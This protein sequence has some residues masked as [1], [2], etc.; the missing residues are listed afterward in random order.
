MSRT[1]ISVFGMGSMGRGM[2]HCLV[3]AGF[4]VTVFNRTAAKAGELSEAG[5]RVAP[6]AVAAATGKDLLLLSLSD[7]AAIDDLL[8]GTLDGV[9][10]PGT[11]VINTSTV[12]AAYSITAAERL[13]DRNIVWVEACVMGNPNMAR[14]GQLRV[15][16]AGAATAYDDVV[17]NVLRVLGSEPVHVGRTGSAC[18]LKLAFNMLLG[19]Q[20]VF[21]AEAVRFAEQAGL[22]RTTVLDAIRSSG[23]CSA[24]LAFRAGFM[25]DRTYEP[26]AFRTAL[27]AKD[28]HLAVAGGRAPAG[29]LPF[30]ELAAEVFAQATEAGDGDKD[31]AVIVEMMLDQA[32]ST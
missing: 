30:T 31:A 14:G 23:F 26:A 16:T 12:S 17:G 9:L 19:G 29:G 22:D 20:I 27:M 8:F 3:Q 7:E 13:L 24:A 4:A 15:F 2:A 10:Q 32:V 11:V 25:R 6:S 18:T 21:L 28:L 1:E 5:A